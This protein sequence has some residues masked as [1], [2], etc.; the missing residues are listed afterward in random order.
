MLTRRG[1]PTH[2]RACT[3]ALGTATLGA[4]LTPTHLPPAAHAESQLAKQPNAIKKMYIHDCI[5]S[6]LSLAIRPHSPVQPPPR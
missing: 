4:K 6:H 1:L 3:A 2:T 5:I